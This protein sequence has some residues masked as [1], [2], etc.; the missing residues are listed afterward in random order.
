[1]LFIP[2]R[3]PMSLPERTDRAQVASLAALL[4][5][6][7]AGD[8]GTSRRRRT[9]IPPEI[10]LDGATTCRPTRRKPPAAEAARRIRRRLCRVCEAR[11]YQRIKRSGTTRPATPPRTNARGRAYTGS[12]SAHREPRFASRR[13]CT[14]CVGRNLMALSEMLNR[15]PHAGLASR[16]RAAVRRVATLNAGFY[17][18][19][20]AS[21]RA[22][23]KQ[24]PRLPKPTL[25]PSIRPSA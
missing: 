5:S 1:M 23:L 8:S 18:T 14:A 9:E 15:H 19:P 20:G 10:N 6:C 12:S 7:V 11:K 25:Q 16:W 24:F 4:G 22:H 3:L 2:R 17:H 13:K 21:P